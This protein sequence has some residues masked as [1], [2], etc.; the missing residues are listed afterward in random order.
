MNLKRWF[1]LGL[2]VLVIILSALGLGVR[3]WYV[4]NLRPPARSA[5]D[6][7]PLRIEAGTSSATVAQQLEDS[8]LIRNSWAFRWYL[9]RRG[10]ST[11]IRAGLYR[12][13]PNQN[14][15][16]LV[17]RL[18]SG[19]TEAHTI[20]ITSGLRLTQITT[21]M[22]KAGYQPADIERALVATYEYS[23][24]KDKP[25]DASL[26]GYLFPDTYQLEIDQPPEKLIDLMLS[27]SEN[28]IRPDIRRGWAAQGLN[29]HQ[30]LTLASIVQKEVSRPEDQQQVAQV[31]IKRLKIGM[32]LEADPTFEYGAALLGETGT[33][34][35]DSIYNTYLHPGLPPTPIAT[36]ELSALEAV[37]KPATTDWLY[38]LSDKEGNTHFTLTEAE[39]KQ[40]IE[41][42]LR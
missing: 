15:P 27:N 11:K 16:Q 31:F 4:L 42:Y 18:A 32:K 10:L 34:A 13:S 19:D 28:Q 29:L 24:L 12:F 35:T 6:I 5:S 25:S 9:Y 1:K 8:G 38:F 39:H 2:I 23:I 17:S 36:I 14:V 21:L 41:Q 26:E 7:I 40:N 30:G 3:S 37:A 22:E 33:P 20:T